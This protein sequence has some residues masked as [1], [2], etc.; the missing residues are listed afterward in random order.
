MDPF[1]GPLIDPFKGTPKPKPS[2][3][4]L[5]EHKGLRAGRRYA[6]GFRAAAPAASEA[7]PFWATLNG[8]LGFL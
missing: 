3:K 1:K 6:V 5:A 8:T 7:S 4:K 2:F